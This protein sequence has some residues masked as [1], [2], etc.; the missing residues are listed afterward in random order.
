MKTFY[1]R[2][3]SE[4]L[5]LG[6]KDIEVTGQLVET[7]NGPAY[8]F[9][10]PVGI[11][12][13]HPR[14]RVLFYPER[15]ANPFFHCLESLWMLAG[16]N[17]VAFPARY[18][19]NIA[20][21]S[22]DGVSFRGAYGH[23][24]RSHYVYPNDQLIVIAHR[25][26]TYPNDRRSVLAMWDPEC[27]LREGNESKDIPCNTHIY[28]S[29]RGSYLHM[30][31]CNRSND[32]IWGAFGANAVHM[33][34][35]QEYMAARVGASVGHYTQFTNNL[36]AYKDV[37]AKHK[38]RN[39][40]YKPYTRFNNP[41]Q[42]LVMEAYRFDIEVRNFCNG[43]RSGFREPFLALTAVP[44][45]YAWGLYKTGEYDAAIAVARTISSED[46]RT[47]CV[48][49]LGRRRAKHDDRIAQ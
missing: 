24:W 29:L 8:E 36:H 10:T 27:D 2:N 28:F 38:L 34:Y 22:D 33:S 6:M 41:S 49:W 46:W 17:D 31:V 9:A 4:A 45:D 47:A 23:R 39:P 37:L 30:T 43:E 7:R 14:E 48:E 20:Q 42:P 32:M 12:Y 15:D 3:V 25:L 35:L 19:S 44:M 21:F 1:V 16:R 13:T 11:T 5:W 26:K 40:D 18:S